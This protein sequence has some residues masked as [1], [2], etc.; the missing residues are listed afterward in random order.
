M[1][2]NVITRN[3]MTSHSSGNQQ[4]TYYE[5]ASIYGHDTFMLDV[6]NVGVAIK[7]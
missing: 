1:T 5:L 4:V 6:N 2:N 3:H 7:V